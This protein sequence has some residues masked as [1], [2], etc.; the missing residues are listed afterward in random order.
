VILTRQRR[1]PVVAVVVAICGL[2]MTGCGDNVGVHPGSA[3]VV[4][5]QSLSMNKIDDTTKLYCQAYVAQSQQSQQTS[6]GP[7]P[8]GAFRSYVASALSKRMLGDAL[9]DHY[10]VEPAPGYQKAVSNYE[11]GL[12][13]AP[14]DQRAAVIEVA[15][16]DAYLQNVQVAIGEQLT[17]NSGQ[18]DAD[19]KANLQRGQV[20]TEDWL[21]DNDARVDPVFG[22][23]VDGGQF[24]P[25]RDQIS[26]PLSPLASE[27]AQA[28]TSQQGPA[29][30]YISALPPSQLCQ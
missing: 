7:I 2:L 15:G 10:G 13:S 1:A 11:Q 25:Q 27:G 23:A 22:I 19:V 18:A 26:Y 29:D 30:S 16:A 3:A 9:A 17:G 8:M 28:L 14:D 12:A 20:A 4:D 6:S 24:S 5:G 21:K